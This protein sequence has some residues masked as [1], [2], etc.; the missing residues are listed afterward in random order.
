MNRGETGAG[1]SPAHIDQTGRPSGRSDH[2]CIVA[3]VDDRNYHFTSSL[4]TA[5]A[6]L[7]VAH[8]AVSPG[9]RNTPMV[10]TLAAE[11][12]IRDWL[13]HDERSAGFFALGIGKAGGFPALTVCTSG[14]AAAEIHPAV[15]EARYGRVPL[16]VVTADRPSDLWDTGSPQTI[17]QRS[18]YGT[19]SLWSHDVDVPASGEAAAGY[20]A[21]LAARL[22]AEARQGP[23]PVHLNL[24]FREPLTPLHGIPAPV[25]PVPR[26]DLGVTTPAPEAIGAVGAAVAGRRGVI[27][28]G[29]QSDPGVAA[30]AAA[31]AA[32]LGF[33]ILPDPQSGLHA[34]PHDRSMVIGAAAALT[35]AGLLDRLV[36]EVVLRIGPPPVGKPLAQWLAG[37]AEIPQ[38][39]VDEDGWRDPGA[40]VSHALRADV[41]PTL[42]AIAAA[43]REPAPADWGAAW[44]EA[45]LAAG[46]AIREALAAHRFPTEPGVAAAI[47]DALPEHALLYVA[48]SMP[49]RDVALTFP[50][51]ARAI[52]IAAN[53]GANGI[54]GFLSSS[55]G[56]AVAWD[57]PVVALSG[58][59]SALHDLTSLATAARLQIPITIVIVDNNGGG[60]FHFLPQAKALEE[61]ER[62]FGTPHGLDLVA[63]VRGLGVAAETVDDPETLQAA[64]GDVPNT[65]RVLVVKTD[66]AA[67]VEVHAAIGA[68]VEEAL[69]R[70]G[71]S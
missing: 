2:F 29:P 40:S 34:G 54:D 17:D 42:L 19:A 67:N 27:V 39:H 48:S 20:P 25:G 69:S 8:A 33:P 24:R 35:Q 26:I 62:Y 16:V 47:A 41:A 53:R 36:P 3:I 45:D 15:I 12:R 7:G 49:I 63:A 13:H 1:R 28:V 56:A 23:G 22:V 60:I 18:I 57:G 4:V 55:L 66:R 5:F 37:H 64:V 61:F 6:D 9:S 71:S 51:T 46:S 10:V 21:A 38:I 32:A 43:V 58:D 70:Q 65:P 11:D 68:A 44:K 14:T 31:A 52:R 50:T 30:A 59:L